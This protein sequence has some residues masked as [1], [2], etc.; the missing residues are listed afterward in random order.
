MGFIG[1]ADVNDT[2][3]REKIIG[4]DDSSITASSSTPA[5]RPGFADVMRK[6]TLEITGDRTYAGMGRYL[7]AWE[8][9][10]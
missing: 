1:R 9:D 7:D 10:Q 6:H 3:A 5:A 4:T 2:L 8:G